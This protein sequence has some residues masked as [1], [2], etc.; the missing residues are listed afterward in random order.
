MKA[1]K[2]AYLDMYHP[3]IAKK[4]KKG[5]KIEYYK[6]GGKVEYY[7]K[8]GYTTDTVPAMLTPGEVVLNKPQQEALGNMMAG[9]GKV[10][11]GQKKAEALFRAIGVPGFKKGA[12]VPVK[13]DFEY[14]PRKLRRAEQLY[15]PKVEGIESDYDYFKESAPEMAM[16]G[17]T[18]QDEPYN[19]S[20][21]IKEQQEAIDPK[22]KYRLMYDMSK[23]DVPEMK[24]MKKNLLKK[25]F[26]AE[27]GLI[28][29]K[30]AIMG[31]Y[32]GG[33]VKKKKKKQKRGAL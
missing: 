23:E 10:N 2:K 18:G 33:K 19:V 27:G 4:L 14:E 3:S 5:G 32:M 22:S 15:A 8:G 12:K 17:K 9:G 30:D 13:S 25:V 6:Q 26:K 1:N 7:E 21:L 28:D 11:S 31:Y 24:P 16:S 29:K 20:N